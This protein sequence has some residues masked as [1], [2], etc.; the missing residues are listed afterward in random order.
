MK[1]VPSQECAGAT[2][3]KNEG[4]QQDKCLDFERTVTNPA[5][6]HPRRKEVFTEVT[7]QK[8]YLY[9]VE[10]ERKVAR[11]FNYEVQHRCAK[12]AKIHVLV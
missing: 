1:K 8:D 7:T 9:C 4:A 10:R 11:R 6:L 5:R 2:G 12:I 3:R